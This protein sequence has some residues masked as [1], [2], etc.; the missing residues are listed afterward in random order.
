M[1]RSAVHHHVSEVKP[2]AQPVVLFR[3]WYR[4]AASGSAGK[5]E[6]AAAAGAAEPTLQWQQLSP[7]ANLAEL[8][9]WLAP[10]VSVRT[11]TTRIR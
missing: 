10:R 6:A 5:A 1:W 8:S 9:Q 11:D 7:G 3:A 2:G 4:T